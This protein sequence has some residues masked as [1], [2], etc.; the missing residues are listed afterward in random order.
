MEPLGRARDW[1]ARGRSS[2]RAGVDRWRAKWW[3]VGQCAVAA[4]LA[5]FIAADLLG[6][7]DEQID[8]LL[9]SGVLE[10]IQPAEIDGVGV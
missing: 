7:D 6:L 8:D 4:A 10:S 9:R 1:G 5:W 3:H 2:G